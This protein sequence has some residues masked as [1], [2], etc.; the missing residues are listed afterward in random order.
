MRRW[1]KRKQ[2]GEAHTEFSTVRNAG[3]EQWQMAAI[4]R[5]WR[6]IRRTTMAH[7]LNFPPACNPHRS[8]CHWLT[9][10]AHAQW[11]RRRGATSSALFLWFQRLG[12]VQGA[13]NGLAVSEEWARNGLIP[14]CARGKKKSTCRIPARSTRATMAGRFVRARSGASPGSAARKS[15]RG[16]AA[17]EASPSGYLGRALFVRW[18]C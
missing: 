5:F 12:T 13:A 10:D 15:G 2:Q 17:T 18:R 4:H 7:E 16:F 14:R 3:H 6:A 1:I 9:V 8:H 11:L